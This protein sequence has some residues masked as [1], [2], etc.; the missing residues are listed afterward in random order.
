MEDE[1]DKAEAGR[2]SRTRSRRNVK[3]GLS[4][5]RVIASQPQN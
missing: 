5:V 2:A 3:D 4:T 1:A